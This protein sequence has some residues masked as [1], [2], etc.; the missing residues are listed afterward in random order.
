MKVAP[1]GGQT[2]DPHGV[3][4]IGKFEPLDMSVG[5]QTLARAANVLNYWAIF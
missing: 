4:V 1:C 5:N 2:L 3:G